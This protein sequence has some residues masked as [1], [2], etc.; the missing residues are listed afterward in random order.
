MS[1]EE[2]PRFRRII[3]IFVAFCVYDRGLIVSVRLIIATSDPVGHLTGSERSGKGMSSTKRVSWS[4][5]MLF[6]HLPDQ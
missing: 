3:E 1:R 5:S 6:I 2:N 4:N